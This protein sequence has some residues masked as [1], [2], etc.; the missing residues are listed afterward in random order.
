[1]ARSGT[2]GKSSE[3]NKREWPQRDPDD[4]IGVN[5][6]GASHG[7]PKA[8]QVLAS[9]TRL[10]ST[11]QYPKSCSPRFTPCAPDSRPPQFHPD[12]TRFSYPF[13]AFPPPK[14]PP[15]LLSHPQIYPPIVISP[16]NPPTGVE[17]T[18]P[19][20]ATTAS[21]PDQATRDA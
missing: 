13:D 12:L 17:P 7:P 14:P 4:G 18:D 8:L 6:A 2:I 11:L 3:T 16:S 21:K 10:F 19:I 15:R 1:M 9:H 20:I 5:Y